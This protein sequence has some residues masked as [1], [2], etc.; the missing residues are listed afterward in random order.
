MYICRLCYFHG[1][2]QM[3]LPVLSSESFVYHYMQNLAVV[4]VHRQS[5]HVADDSKI[6]SIIFT[7]VDH[8]L[9]RQRGLGITTVRAFANR[10]SI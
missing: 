5:Y 9:G 2:I 4:R 10:V 6:T 8:I 1:V 7:T 3:M